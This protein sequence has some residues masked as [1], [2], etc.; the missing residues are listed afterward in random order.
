[1][2]RKILFILIALLTTMTA[3]ADDESWTS[4]D[5][6]VTLSGNTL[7]VS[8]PGAMADYKAGGAPWNS[9]RSSTRN[10]VIEDGVTRIGNNAFYFLACWHRLPFL[11]V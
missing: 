5:C 9:H 8:G 10:I 4:G 6:T 7:T 3:W 1:M 11:P 2:K